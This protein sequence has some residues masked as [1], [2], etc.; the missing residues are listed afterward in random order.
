MLLR[1]SSLKLKSTESISKIYDD[2]YVTE[3]KIPLS[4]FKNRER[5]TKW[6][7]NSYMRNTQNNSWITWNLAPENLLFFNLAFT[8]TM[9]F[10]KPLSKSKPKKSFIP[11]IN[12]I[13]FN[14]FETFDALNSFFS[15]KFAKNEKRQINDLKNYI[16]NWKSNKKQ[17]S[18]STT[19]SKNHEKATQQLLLPSSQQASSFPSSSLSSPP[20]SSK[21]TGTPGS[22]KA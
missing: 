3:W 9:Y 17:T 13:A 15:A 14:D 22:I 18:Q 6:G 19:R 10:E 2:Y 5:E 7:V 11:Y 4:A 21:R 20:I 12:G 1:A 8:G 16:K